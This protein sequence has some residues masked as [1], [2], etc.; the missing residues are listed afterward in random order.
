MTKPFTFGKLGVEI[1]SSIDPSV[2]LPD[3]DTPFRI[4]VMGDFSGRSGMGG[5]KLRSTGERYRIQRVDRD[6]I[7]ELMVRLGAGIDL[8]LGGEGEPP[9]TLWFEELDDFH[10]DQVYEHL[11]SFR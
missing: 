11:G 7:E 1:V 8:P 6:N 4:L 5:V 3:S 2:G 10:P 9:A